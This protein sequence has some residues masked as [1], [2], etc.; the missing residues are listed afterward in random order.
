MNRVLLLPKA[1][2]K[3]LGPEAEVHV[4]TLYLFSESYALTANSAGLRESIYCA[5]FPT[6]GGWMMNRSTA[7]SHA[8]YSS[9]C[10]AKVYLHPW[11]KALPQQPTALLPEGLRRVRS[12]IK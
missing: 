11:R 4:F 10:P 5:R 6:F 1:K 12:D 2:C 9:N 3:V 8:S 7:V